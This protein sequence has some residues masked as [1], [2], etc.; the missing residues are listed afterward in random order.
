M[1]EKPKRVGKS[2]L[3]EH[4]K[5]ILEKEGVNLT[6]VE[7]SK[8]INSVF[9]AVEELLLTEG[10]VNISGFGTFVTVKTRSK[11]GRNPQSGAP[12]QV[13]EKIRPKFRPAQQLQLNV[14][15][16]KKVE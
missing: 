6:G 4:L 7:I 14:A 10:K 2:Q 5:K 11:T 12:V 8:T 16:G 9:D 3:T 1:A 15:A 13:P